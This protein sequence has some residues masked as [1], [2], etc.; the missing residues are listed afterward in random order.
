M[1]V[2]CKTVSKDRSSWRLNIQ[3]QEKNLYVIDYECNQ[4]LFALFSIGSNQL[5]LTI[6]KQIHFDDLDFKSNMYV[7]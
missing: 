3:Q 7:Y 1:L 2:S 6:E 5:T 4:T